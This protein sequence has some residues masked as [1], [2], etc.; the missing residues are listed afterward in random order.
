MPS[1]MRVAGRTGTRHLGAVA[2]SQG[3]SLEI[4]VLALLLSLSAPLA[5]RAQSIVL[6]GHVLDVD[7]RPL[8]S[9]SVSVAPLDGVASSVAQTG[10]DG[11]YRILW[12]GGATAFFIAVRKAGYV[13]Q[14]RQVAKMGTD[15]VMTVA[16]FRMVRSAQSISAVH[17]VAS[18]PPPVRE[19]ERIFA[20][21]GET[22]LTLDPSSG[23]AGATTGDATGDLQL[24][25]AAIPG[26][27][28]TPGAGGSASYTFAGLDEAQNRV[29]LNGA[30]VTPAAPRD[31]GL[32][33]VTTTGYDATEAMSGVRAEWTILGANYVPNRTLR[34]TFDTPGLQAS[35]PGAV[36]GPRTA[37]PILSGVL[38][39]PGKGFVRF[40]NTSFQLSR[41][42]GSLATLASIDDASLNALG[43]SADSVRRIVGAL[44]ALGI[45]SR[46]RVDGAI[47]RTTTRASVYSRLDLTTNSIGNI[48]RGADERVGGQSN[49]ADQGHVFYLL[50]GGEA[51]ESN[52]TGAG[53]LT[54]PAF[55]SMA[56]SRSF[57]AQ[58]FNSVYPRDYILNETRLTATFGG[59]RFEPMSSL[60]GALV[61]TTGVGA[62]GGA[63][64]VLQAAGSGGAPSTTR[65]WSVQARND[66]HWSSPGGRH[67]WKVALESLVDGYSAQRDASR[68]RFDYLS[69]EDFV[70]NR[71]SAFMRSIAATSTDV[72][73][74]HVAAGFG[75]A[76]TPSRS[77]AWQYGVRVEGH[78]LQSDA[79]RNR[80]VDSLFGVRTGSLPMRVSVAPMVGFTWRYKP[81]PSGFPSSSHLILGGIRDYRG[82]LATRD[83]LGVF[84]ETGMA[85]GLRELRCIDAA[86]PQPQWDRYGD[87]AAIPTACALGADPE[88]AQS[89]LPVSLY[90]PAFALGHSVRADLQWT[91]PLSRTVQLSVRGMTAI[92]ARQPSIV[93]LN[94]DG[95]PRFSLADEG[96]RP[97]FTPVT[98]VGAENGLASTVPS[99]RDPQ[100][101]HVTERRSDLRSRSSSL[102]GELRVY[103]VMSRFGS[104]V[105]VPLWLAYTFTDTRRQFT[106]FTGTTEGDPRATGWEPATTGRHAVLFGATLHVPDWFR[107]TPGLTL[108][109]GMRYTPIVQGD[110]NADGLSSNDRAFVFDPRVT[111][112]AVLSAGMSA[113]LDGASRQPARCL[114]AQVGRIA[115][116]S[117]CTG[118]W[119]ATL[120]AIVAVDPARI[121]LQ[122][123]GTVQLR[124]LNV[125][126]G[127]DQLVHGSDQLHGWGQPAYPDPVLLQVRGFDPVARRY[128]YSVNKSFGDT[129]VYQSLFQAPFRI[130]IDVSLDVGPNRERVERTR[131]LSCGTTSARSPCPE[132]RPTE[133]ARAMM[134]DSA[135]LADRIRRAHDPRNLF[136][137]VIRRADEFQLSAAQTD[138]LEALGRSHGAFR[139][140]TYDALAGGI[141]R[142]GAALDDETVA[143]RWREA[144]RAVARSE[145]NTGVLARAFLTP[146]QAEGIF[147][148]S[149]PLSVRPIIYDE[150]ELER[151][152]RLWQQRVF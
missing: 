55:A 45:G 43:V 24:A 1:L 4:A 150:R 103:P 48:H 21:P 44:G 39:G 128:R 60:P 11:R 113:L 6:T 87:V 29:T 23:F 35:R 140:S 79:A 96:N 36:L 75:D 135:T 133:S 25:L 104:G 94:F 10:V 121:R 61:L 42:A 134:P 46:A 15:S 115:A 108:R 88:L 92:N 9:A 57:T 65:A 107:I 64:T 124:V 106:G 117:S 28:V 54:L 17:V 86:T 19:S 146:R 56:R 151:T 58:A 93:D 148:R 116:P 126:A 16:E 142:Q 141:V 3:G 38:G 123:R 90:S 100:F 70:A 98:S 105:K 50:V 71:P 81:T 68:G 136:D 22:E 14:T 76:Y 131:V 130:A 78:G 144:I 49:G 8:A 101:T 89:A 129:R 127:L 137:P 147:G 32:L 69:V 63:T 82:T 67:V 31:G 102:T 41:Q 80:V 52:G 62:L 74:V 7:R 114:G 40:H 84:G 111:S 37:A 34:L 5:A 125:L 77:L 152:L 30:D 53:V 143:R 109:S 119:T 27:A 132:S 139:D 59:S 2:R 18:R 85:S 145:W 120:N 47:S 66:T 51:T 72:R 99:R 95:V 83:A 122:N 138:S 20:K 112:D 73:G 33:R 97:V 118:P 91:A 13:T 26:I 110:V 149:G 12:N